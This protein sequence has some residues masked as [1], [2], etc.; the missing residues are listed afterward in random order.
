MHLPPSLHGLLMGLMATFWLHPAFADEEAPIEACNRLVPAVSNSVDTAIP[1]V[2]IDEDRNNTEDLAAMAGLY[3][4]RSHRLGGITYAAPKFDY[5][6]D[7]NLALLPENQGVCARP[8]MHLTLGYN[9]FSIFMNIDLPRG[10]CLYNAVL[11]HEMHH[12]DIYRN[13]L[14]RNLPRFKQQVED[15]FNGRIYHF[16][17]IYEAKQYTEILGQVFM[18]KLQRVFTSEVNAE[19]AALDTQAEYARVQLSCN[20][21]QTLF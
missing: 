19:Q 6:V 5:E 2:R 13:Y 4:D 11:S 8:A 21:T 7:P 15:K 14:S 10:T 20:P 17:T 16:N 12:V 3:N 9:N 18:Q 1:D